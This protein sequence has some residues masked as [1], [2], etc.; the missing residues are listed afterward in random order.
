MQSLS[1]GRQNWAI[2]RKALLSNGF[3]NLSTFIAMIYVIYPT[4]VWI[5][6]TVVQ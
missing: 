6:D 4:T 5:C 3:D 1:L 2:E